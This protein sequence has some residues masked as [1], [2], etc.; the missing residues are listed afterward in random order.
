[1]SKTRGIDCYD[2]GLLGGHD[3]LSVEWWHDYL[4][5]ELD[6]A[7]DF[8][9]QQVEAIDDELDG[10]NDKLKLLEKKITDLWQLI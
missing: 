5:A 3:G 10:A 4:R 2:A 8:Y 6:R 1:M 9:A 7:H